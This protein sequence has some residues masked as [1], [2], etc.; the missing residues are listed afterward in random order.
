[1]YQVHEYLPAASTVNLRVLFGI[2]IS[3]GI[4]HIYGVINI[5]LYHSLT[6]L[7]LFLTHLLLTQLLM[8]FVQFYSLRQICDIFWTPFPPFFWKNALM[9]LDIYSPPYNQSILLVEGI[10]HTSLAQAILKPFLKKAPLDF[11]NLNNYSYRPI[12]NLHFI[13]KLLERIIAR[14]I[15]THLMLNSL[16]ALFN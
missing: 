8:K 9:Y 13:S 15:E 11:E 3:Y 16:Y 5:P 1:M 12:S 7:F 14:R 10:F 6:T 4:Y 2:P